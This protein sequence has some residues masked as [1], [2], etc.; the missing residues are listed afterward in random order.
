MWT[1]YISWEGQ[2]AMIVDHRVLPASTDN[3]KD[4][5]LTSID[6]KWLHSFPTKMDFPS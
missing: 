3:Q 4:P 5:P 1:A 2:P 6:T